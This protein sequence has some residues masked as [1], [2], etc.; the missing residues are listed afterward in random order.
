[1]FIEVELEGTSI[2]S[3]GKI[4]PK[5]LVNTKDIVSVQQEQGTELRIIH[6][7]NSSKLYVKDS[8]EKLRFILVGV[9]FAKQEG[10]GDDD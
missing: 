3:M 1:M 10:G 9:L 2:V 5:M 7:R 6:M 4:K 8:Y